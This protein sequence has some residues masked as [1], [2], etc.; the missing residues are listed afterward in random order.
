MIETILCAA[1]LAKFKG[2]KI[3]PLLTTKA[4]YP[5]IV[6]EAFYWLMQ[7]NLFAGDYRVLKYVGM[8]KTVYLCAYL[9]LVFRC[10]L[11]SQAIIGSGCILLGG[12][13]NDIAIAANHGK[14]PVF[15]TLSYITGYIKPDS[16]ARAQDIH[17]LGSAGTQMKGLTDIFDLGYSI[18]SIGDVLIRAFVFLILYGAIKYFNIQHV[19][20]KSLLGNEGN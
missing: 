9:G 12:I 5:I 7:I 4:I 15:P 11:Y 13:C 18:L 14:M 16:M 10:E 8:F 3:K 1:I 20:K 19:K 2:Y 17:I 6:V